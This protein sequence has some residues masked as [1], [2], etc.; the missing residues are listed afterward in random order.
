VF[1]RGADL[2]GFAKLLD[3]VV[4]GVEPDPRERKPVAEARSLE[5]EAAHARQVAQEMTTRAVKDRMLV[6][7][8]QYDQ[9]AAEAD[10]AAAENSSL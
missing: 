7:A 4:L 2:T 10:R 3:R 1:S 6:Q 8:G 9:L 5:L